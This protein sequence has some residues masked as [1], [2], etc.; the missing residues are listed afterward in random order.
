MIAQDV[1]DRHTEQRDDELKVVCGQV[2]ASENQVHVTK[3]VSG[4][5]IV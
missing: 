4:V 1:V 2:A 3:T 5:G